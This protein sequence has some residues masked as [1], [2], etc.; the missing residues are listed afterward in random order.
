L[1]ARSNSFTCDSFTDIVDNHI[2]DNHILDNASE[3]GQRSSHRDSLFQYWLVTVGAILKIRVWWKRYDPYSRGLIFALIIVFALVPSFVGYT[4]Y[5][6]DI[7]NAVARITV[8]L[9]LI[10]DSSSSTFYAF[11]PVLIPNM[12]MDIWG[13]LLGRWIGVENALLIFIMLTIVLLF[14]SVQILR[15]MIVGQPSLLVGAASMFLIQSGT[16]RWGLMNYEIAA[17]IILVTIAFT[18]HHIAQP[19]GMTSPG[20]IAARSALC[21]LSVMCSVF[22]VAIYGCYV[23]GRLPSVLQALDYKG[24]AR[25]VV[26]LAVPFL[27]VLAFLA[28]AH[29]LPPAGTHETVWTIYG[30]VSGIVALFY[31][32]GPGL[33]LPIAIG[34]AA[35]I[36]L[37]L[38]ICRCRVAPSQRLG[39]I[40]MVIL[41]VALPSR[42]YGVDAIE[43][44]LAQPIA[45]LLIASTELSLRNGLIWAGR[46]RLVGAT[47]V[48]LA[49]ARP[50]VTIASL[51]PV[52]QLRHSISRLFETIPSGSRVLIATDLPEFRYFGHRIW[53]LPLLSAAEQHG[54]VF[55][56][57]MFSNFFTQRKHPYDELTSDTIQI[58]V[59]AFPDLCPWTHVLLIGDTGSLPSSLPLTGEHRDGAS[60]IFEVDRTACTMLDRSDRP[61]ARF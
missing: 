2:V 45:L 59:D 7:P 9:K 33:E 49:L 38:M 36:V 8:N 35:A 51:R 28:V 47:F 48:V 39:L 61:R 27:P 14:T 11:R 5:L 19:S 4:I 55:T 54:D 43:Y 1:F 23:A 57:S 30:K 3:T 58:G 25:K 31:V 20:N 16:F 15:S 24:N 32:R 40:L 50:L 17:G 13:L 41:Y 52:D 26:A 18:E 37:L 44:R 12:S 42:L 22:P 34:F 10:A 6:T 21:L 60:A 29:D 53:H 56:G 46:A